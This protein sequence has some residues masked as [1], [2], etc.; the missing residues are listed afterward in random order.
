MCLLTTIRGDDETC[1]RLHRRVTLV[2]GFL[3]SLL[4]SVNA[5]GDAEVK[6]GGEKTP[7]LLLSF[8]ADR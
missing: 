3:F 7:P 1:G 6:A 8:M 5:K 2:K 4:A